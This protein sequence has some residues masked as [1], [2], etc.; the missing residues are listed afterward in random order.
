MD[1]LGGYAA[2]GLLVPA[3]NAS[4]L[5][6]LSPG[7]GRAQGPQLLGCPA[8]ASSLPRAAPHLC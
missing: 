5:W 7:V 3:Q 1:A 4:A 2:A 8:A 6:F